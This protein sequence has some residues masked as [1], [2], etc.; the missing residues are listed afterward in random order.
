MKKRIVSLLLC[1][2]LVLSMAPT[3]LAAGN[4]TGVAN[5]FN[6]YLNEMQELDLVPE[7]FSGMDLSKNITR[8]EMCR[9][10]VHALEKIT[11]YAIEPER[12]DYFLDTSADY[13]VKAYELG[14]VHGDGHG[15][16]HPDDLLT[17]QEFFQIIENFCRAAAFLPNTEGSSLSKFKDTADVPNWAREATEICVKYGYVQGVDNGNGLALNPQGNTP[18]QEAM[19]M[20]LRAYKTL[21]EY[22]FYVRNAQ[23]QVEDNSDGGSG[24]TGK[25]MV[26]DDVTIVGVDKHMMVTTSSLNIRSSWST[27]GQVLGAL[28]YGADITVTGLCANGWVQI[29]YKGKTAYVSG[30]YVADY[31]DVDNSA[32]DT[33]VE[34]ANF[35]LG[36]VGYPY[37][38]GAESPSQ[39]FDCSGLV[40]YVYGQYGHKLHRTADTQ[41]DND[42]TAVSYNNLQ[43][44]DLVFFGSGSYAN[45]VGIYIGN[46]NFV[47][48]ANPSSGVRISSMNETYYASRYLC[49]RQIIVN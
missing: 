30:D 44:G 16:F 24:A 6:P 21:N 31:E 8:G 34:I 45:H 27:N 48:A 10:A 25:D 2:V 39:G 47:H 32:S 43:V 12:S 1:A 5:W 19:V 33:A 49:A 18:R 23:V 4:F 22:Y 41:M 14:I 11:G 29:S 20:F 15:Y 46:N 26:V 42:G 35:A 9:L 7:A 3:A 40:Y 36:F 38:Y 13:I 37:V 17:R 28:P